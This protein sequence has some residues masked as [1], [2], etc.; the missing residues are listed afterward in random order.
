MLPISLVAQST[1]DDP[2]TESADNFS[3]GRTILTFGLGGFSKEENYQSMK[4]ESSLLEFQTR[5]GHIL[6]KN[7][8]VGFAFAFANTS[9][10]VNKYGFSSIDIT[11]GEADILSMEIYIKNYLTN[12]KSI[13]PYGAFFA[14]RAMVNQD[15]LKYKTTNYGLVFGAIYF[16]HEHIG[17]EGSVKYAVLDADLDVNHSEFQNQDVDGS[18]FL[19]QIGFVYGF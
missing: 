10:Y 1:M 7:F 5:I 19:Y 3:I 14:G 12:H 17:I 8:E 16:M 9:T 18:S 6:G 2:N 11:G 15:A 13:R 4:V